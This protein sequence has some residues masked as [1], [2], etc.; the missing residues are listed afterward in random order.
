M[1]LA[2]IP[3]SLFSQHLF[4]FL[5]NIIKRES[6]SDANASGKKSLYSEQSCGLSFQA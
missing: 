6:P 5:K 3:L 2:V 1:K 4:P